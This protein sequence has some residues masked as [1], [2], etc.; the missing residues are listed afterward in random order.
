MT[1][2]KLNIDFEKDMLLPLLNDLGLKENFVSLMKH[3]KEQSLLEEDDY[4]LV[5]YI[6]LVAIV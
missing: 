3:L 1:A 4:S 5:P 6:K 2:D